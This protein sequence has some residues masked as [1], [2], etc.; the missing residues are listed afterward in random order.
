MSPA[1]LL[2]VAAGT[3]SST[4][5]TV[6]L[7]TT[8]GFDVS[9]VGGPA[10]VTADVLGFYAADDTVVAGYGLSGGYQPLELTPLVESAAD[11]AIPP[12]GR[13]LLAVDLGGTATA[14]TRALLVSVTTKDTTAPGSLSVSRCL[15]CLG[16]LGRLGRLGARR[17]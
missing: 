3:T 12:G 14:H 16:R 8:S 15:G 11:T 10:T 17:A 2:A 4:L 9:A 1:P 7:A 13:V 6:P 5:V